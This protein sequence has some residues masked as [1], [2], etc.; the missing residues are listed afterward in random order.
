MTVRTYYRET[1]D[2]RKVVYV[3]YSIDGNRKRERTVMFYYSQPKNS[4][5]REHNKET[6]KLEENYVSK[7][8]LKIQSGELGIQVSKGGFNYLTQHR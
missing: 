4:S 8:T 1:K 3:D 5:E 6:K 7:L 2:G